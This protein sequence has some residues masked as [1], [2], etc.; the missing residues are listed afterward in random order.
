[1]IT[2]GGDRLEILGDVTH[3]VD[4][5]WTLSSSASELGS[6]ILVQYTV[7]CHALSRSGSGVDVFR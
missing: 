3:G 7:R 2:Y 6:T 5:W 1:M 4:D